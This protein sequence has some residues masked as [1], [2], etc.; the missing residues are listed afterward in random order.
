MIKV[1]KMDKENL[2]YEISELDSINKINLNKLEENED[3]KEIEIEGY[4]YKIS[5]ITTQ[6]DYSLNSEY[7]VK[8]IVF[9][10]ENKVK[11]EKFYLGKIIEQRYDYF[12]KYYEDFDLNYKEVK[13]RKEIRYE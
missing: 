2:I 3:F 1:G 12:E 8:T 5:Y 6:N 10:I 7:R 9:E 13:E 11:N 4:K